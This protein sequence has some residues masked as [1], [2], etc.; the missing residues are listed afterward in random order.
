M[1]LK[2]AE[3]FDANF[4]RIRADLRVEDGCIAEIAPSLPGEGLDFT[5]CVILPGFIDIHIHGCNGA[6]FGDGTVS[7]LETMS[8]YLARQGITSFCPSSVTA[9]EECIA[10]SY[11]AAASYMGR[12]KGAYIHGVHMEGPYLS[13]KRKG[14]QPEAH[15]RKPDLAEFE[16]L[17]QLCPIRLVAVAP[18]AEGAFEFARA[19]SPTCRVSAAHSAASCELVAEAFANGFSHATHLFNG[20]GPILARE[21]GLA[22]A[23][24]DDGS[25]S[26]E[27]ICDGRHID[28]ALLRVAFR[29]LEEDRSVVVSDAMRASGLVDGTFDLGGQTVY[30]KN[31][32]ATLADGSL[33]GSTSNLF[34]EF[35]N[36]LRY[37]IPLRQ[38]VK[39]CSINPARVIGTDGETGSLAVGKAADLLVL[40]RDLM[41][42][43]AV[44]I[45]GK[46]RAL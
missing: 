24:L 44:F 4:N 38:A 33:A 8:V 43:Q 31:G 32:C 1:L 7:S 11:S 19:V 3:L 45:N 21:P 39:S 14:A 41:R 37:G 26:A 28:P 35:R 30:V 25:V 40:D 9:P 12:E 29:L 23:V 22:V 34:E 5:D 17:N 36:L 27:L 18:E 13:V 46:Q 10:A 42:I 15:I 16:R 20:M 2:N 6:D